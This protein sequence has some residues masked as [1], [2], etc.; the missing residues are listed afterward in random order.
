MI[1]FVKNRNFGEIC[2][3]LLNQVYLVDELHFG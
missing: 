3:A 2:F 1:L